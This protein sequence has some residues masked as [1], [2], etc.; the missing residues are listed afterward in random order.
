MAQQT[1]TSTLIKE[2]MA[3]D[4]SN[5]DDKNYY[6][7]K[8]PIIAFMTLI[9]SAMELEKEQIEDAFHAGKWNGYE[10]AKGESEIKDAAEYYNETYGDQE[11]SK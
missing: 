3:F 5:N 8:I 1:A 11:G 9:T 4:N 7:F 10:Y 6:E 2:L